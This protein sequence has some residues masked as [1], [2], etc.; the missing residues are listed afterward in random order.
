MNLIDW[1]RANGVN[2][3][4][5]NRWFL[6]GTLPVPGVRINSRS[7]L[8]QVPSPAVATRAALYARVSSHDQ[9]DDLAPT[10]SRSTRPNTV[11]RWWTGSARSVLE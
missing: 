9:K 7:I 3:Y 1:A 8:V 5:A 4:T 2:T 6:E 11:S 10:G